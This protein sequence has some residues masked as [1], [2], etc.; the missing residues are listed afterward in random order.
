MSASA[1]VTL[2][3]GGISRVLIGKVRQQAC[4]TR[5]EMRPLK[6]CLYCSTA[7]WPC[8][9]LRSIGAYQDD[10]GKLCRLGELMT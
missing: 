7:L 9:M 5:P 8:P 10:T 3:H 6:I 2:Q 1:S 4:V